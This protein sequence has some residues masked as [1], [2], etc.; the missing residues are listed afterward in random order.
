MVEG[1]EGSARPQGMRGS[2]IV[3][4]ANP[5]GTNNVLFVLGFGDAAA[6]SAKAALVL[7][8]NALTAQR[9]LSQMQAAALTGMPQ[10]RV[11]RVR[12]YKL[13]NSSL[14]RLMRALVSLDQRFEA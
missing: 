5:E 4:S 14:E 1:V 6:C 2:A 3:R 8:L 7:K 9:G 12:R 11:S 10:S 13:Q